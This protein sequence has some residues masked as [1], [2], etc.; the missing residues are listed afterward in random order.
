[1]IL[2]GIFLVCMD[3]AVIY[4]V[5]ADSIKAHY[6]TVSVRFLVI[7]TMGIIMAGVTWKPPK[8]F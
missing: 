4:Q 1:M 8:K 7:I 6:I 3:A 2:H 5:T